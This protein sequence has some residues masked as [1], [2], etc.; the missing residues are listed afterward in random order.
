MS[1]SKTESTHESTGETAVHPFAI[2]YWKMCTFVLGIGFIVAVA[3]HAGP[4]TAHAS[5]QPNLLT[6]RQTQASQT[7]SVG[8]FDSIDGQPAFVIVNQDGQRVGALPM[9][10]MKSD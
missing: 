3:S 7:L 4:S 10:A 9:S 6:L 8:G 5:A 1:E 2:D